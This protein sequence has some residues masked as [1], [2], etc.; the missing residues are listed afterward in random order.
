MQIPNRDRLFSICDKQNLELHQKAK[1][2]AFTKWKSV[3]LKAVTIH[4]LRSHHR[5]WDLNAI[6]CAWFQPQNR[7]HRTANLAFFYNVHTTVVWLVEVSMNLGAAQAWVQTLACM[8]LFPVNK[9][10][11][12]GFAYLVSLVCLLFSSSFIH[13]SQDMVSLFPWSLLFVA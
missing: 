12:L 9:S 4:F 2:F 11:M 10:S 1:R 8:T 3:L 7:K 6:S 5:R 13:I